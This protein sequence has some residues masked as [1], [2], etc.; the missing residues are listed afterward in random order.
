MPRRGPVSL[1]PLLLVGLGA[2]LR[3]TVTE[4][5]V[6]DS[7][8]AHRRATVLGGYYLLVQELGGLAAPLLGALAG[9]VGIGAAFGS[10]SLAL[11]ACSALVLLLHR[12]L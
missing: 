12:R 11:A 7:T 10:V 2:S 3:M 5:L 4:V 9:A 6:L 1:L 8:P